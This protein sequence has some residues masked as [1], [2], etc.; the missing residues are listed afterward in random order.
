MFREAARRGLA[1]RN[2]PLLSLALPHQVDS[3]SAA[4]ECQLPQTEVMGISQTNPWEPMHT[5]RPREAQDLP[6]VTQ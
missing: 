4:A 3:L 1:G 5:L 6:E 2:S